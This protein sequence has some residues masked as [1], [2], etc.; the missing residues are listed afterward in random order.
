MRTSLFV[1]M[2]FLLAATAAAAERKLSGPE[3]ETVLTGN[4]VVG[5][6]DKGQ[7][8]QFFG[9]GGDT[10]YVRG[11]EP[12][13]PGAWKIKGDDYCSQWPPSLNWSCYAVSADLEVAQ[14]TITW[15]GESGTKFPG[16]VRKGND[17]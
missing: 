11:S 5:D 16:I 4:T 3:I 10:L 17:F 13:S 6:S 2:S 12:P 15:V 9:K 8:K 1:L 14:P 7:W